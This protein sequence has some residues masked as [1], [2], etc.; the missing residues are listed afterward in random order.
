MY[1]ELE[2]G[3]TE[4]FHLCPQAQQPVRFNRFDSPEIQS[5]SYPDFIWVPTTAAQSH[6]THQAVHCSPHFPGPIEIKPAALPAQTGEGAEYCRRRCAN[7]EL[8]AFQD[9][10]L[11]GKHHRRHI[12]LA[13][14]QCIRP[15]GLDIAGIQLVECLLDGGLVIDWMDIWKQLS[16]SIAANDILIVQTLDE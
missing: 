1:L 13:G 2:P 7:D 10:T 11:L 4:D 14:D 15:G 16:G 12:A 5:I 3:S 8:A 9:Y 6:S